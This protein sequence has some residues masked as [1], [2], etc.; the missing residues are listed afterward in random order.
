MFLLTLLTVNTY[1]ASQIQRPEER[2]RITYSPVFLDQVEAGNVKS[3][4]AAGD[5][6]GRVPEGGHLPAGQGGRGADAP[7]RDRGPGVADTEEL[8]ALLREKGVAVNAEP[9]EEE[10]SLIE[11]LISGLLPTLLM[12]GLLIWP[13]ERGLRPRRC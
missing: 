7:V 3:I 1:L 12:V 2:V 13:P 10:P 5:G 11:S 8:S 9:P 6:P 4:L